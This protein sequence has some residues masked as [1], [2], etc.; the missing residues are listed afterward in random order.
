MESNKS[1]IERFS[2]VLRP[3]AYN[4][5]LSLW[6]AYVENCIAIDNIVPKDQIFHIKYENL[7]ENPQEILTKVLDFTG[8]V[9]DAVSIKN[10]VQGINKNRRYAFSQIP[11]LVALYKTIQKDPLLHRLGYDNIL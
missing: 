10:S 5:A 11:K 9:S 3:D 8:C 6:F 4:S 7:L 1:M 2:N